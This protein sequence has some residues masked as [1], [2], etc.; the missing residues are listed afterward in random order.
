MTNFRSI[1]CGIGEN[2]KKTHRPEIILALRLCLDTTSVD[3]GKHGIVF[4]W[5][6]RHFPKKNLIKIDQIENM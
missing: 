3:G 2:L 5:L 4:G 6:W 1:L